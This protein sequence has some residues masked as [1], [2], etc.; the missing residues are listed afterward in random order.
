M[1]PLLSLRENISLSE[2]TKS[3]RRTFEAK[4]KSKAFPHTPLPHHQKARSKRWW[5][6]ASSRAPY[7]W[8]KQTDRHRQGAEAQREGQAKTSTHHPI[9][10]RAS[11]QHALHGQHPPEAGE[12]LPRRKRARHAAVRTTESLQNHGGR[13]QRPDAGESLTIRP[14][15]FTSAVKLR[16]PM[17]ISC[18]PPL[19]SRLKVRR[20][21]GGFVSAK[22]RARRVRNE[23]RGARPGFP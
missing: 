19:T 15:L 6:I 21:G 8:K 4:S 17:S 11:T 7:A 20:V 14:R 2:Y 1:Q 3:P 9:S 12:V 10:A 18:S 5:S 22:T 23:A 16:S 13:R